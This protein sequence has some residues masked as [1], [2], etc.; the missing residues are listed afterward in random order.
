MAFPYKKMDEADFAYIRSLTSPDRVAVG[1]EIASEYYHDE[2][3]CYGIF[4]PELY[5]EAEN[6]EEISRIMAYCNEKNIPV[7]I[8]G[9]GT[10]WPAAPTANM[11]GLCFLLCG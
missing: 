1:A 7:V 6:K 5:V 11:A 9:A 10:D 8:R 2:M 3:P 4:P